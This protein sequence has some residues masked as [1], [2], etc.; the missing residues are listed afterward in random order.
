MERKEDLL[1]AVVSHFSPHRAA[2]MHQHSCWLRMAH[3]LSLQQVA[4][5]LLNQLSYVAIACLAVTA[6]TTNHLFEISH[7]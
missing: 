6:A 5:A 1:A 7:E 2:T 3:P 4:A